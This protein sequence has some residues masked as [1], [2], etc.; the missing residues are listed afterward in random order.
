MPQVELNIQD[1][2]KER[3]AGIKKAVDHAD[4][5]NENWSGKAYAHLKL[6]LKAYPGEFMAER[7]RQWCEETDFPQPPHMRAYGGIIRR[8]AFEGL[9]TKV[10]HQQVSNPKAHCA[11]ASVWVANK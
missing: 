10:R 1:A 5:V 3:D 8:A 9:I 6:F 2:M 11:F 7:F 4:S